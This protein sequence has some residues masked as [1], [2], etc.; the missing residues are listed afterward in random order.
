MTFSPQFCWVIFE[1]LAL[2]EFFLDIESNFNLM[3][4]KLR[5]QVAQFLRQQN[6]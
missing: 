6:K 2:F 5:L 4:L 1:K 3:T